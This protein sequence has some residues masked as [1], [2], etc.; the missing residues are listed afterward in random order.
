MAIF[1]GTAGADTIVGG[2]DADTIHGLDGNDRLR[3][4]LGPDQIFG[5]GGDD[6][7]FGTVGDDT[8]DGGAG[9]DV[10]TGSF[11]DNFLYG[12]AGNDSLL[13]GRHINSDVG[14]T[15]QFEDGGDGDDYVSAYSNYDDRAVAAT[16]LGGAGNDTVTAE[17]YVTATMDGGSGDDFIQF[18]DTLASRTATLGP[19]MDTVR[20]LARNDF[21]FV[22]SVTITDFVPGDAGEVMIFEDMNLLL[23]HWSGANPFGTGHLRLIQQGSTAILQVDRDGGGDGFVDFV[24][25]LN[26]DANQFT[27]HN[28]FG[29]ASGLGAPPTSVSQ[30]KTGGPGPDD[31]LGGSGADSLAGGGGGDTIRGGEGDDLIS[32]SSGSNYLRGDEGNDSISGGV[33]FDDINGNMGNDT[34]HGNDGDDWVVGGKGND[35][36]T[37]DKGFDI[38]YGN[39][40]DD[41]VSGGE[42]VDWVRG[43]QGNDSVSGGAGNDWIWGD[44]GDDTLSGGAGADIFHSFSGAGIDR[45]TDFSVAEGD[46]VQVDSYFIVKQVGED[47][48]ITFGAGDQVVLVGVQVST[49]ATYSIFVL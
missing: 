34:A 37:G 28:L 35:L 2:V 48:V 10:L 14:A 8:L 12:G 3:G 21:T 31:L 24:R 49:L 18:T 16:M 36:L 30:S 33:G 22:G 4:G 46:G 15:T 41:T 43:G 44:R 45:I 47:T 29:Y 17:G 25:F 1:N 42:G 20:F 27:A 7:L 26:A 9:N 6:D 40:G 11:G 5:D 39:L 13:V 19:G 23:N 38:V 32:D